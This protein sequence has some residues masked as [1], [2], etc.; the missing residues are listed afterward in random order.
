M[1]IVKKSHIR[2][3]PASG[4]LRGVEFRRN[5]TG[6]ELSGSSTC[7]I[8]GEMRHSGADYRFRDEEIDPPRG[9]PFGGGGIHRNR[10]VWGFQPPSSYLKGF[11]FQKEIIQVL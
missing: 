1:K 5:E 8:S 6:E 4:P 3:S 11:N 7:R 9:R 2:E 10:G